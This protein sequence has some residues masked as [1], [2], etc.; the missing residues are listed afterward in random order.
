MDLDD[1][2]RSFTS[3]LDLAN[4]DAVFDKCL[5]IAMEFMVHAAG[6]GLH[7]SLIQVSRYDGD[8]SR[9]HPKWENAPREA[10]IHYLVRIDGKYVDWTRRQFDALAPIPVVVTDLAADGWSRVWE[11]ERE[12][13]PD[14]IRDTLDRVPPI[15]DL[16]L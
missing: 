15:S 2:L 9:C 4:P 3:S 8:M 11:I 12:G 16:S 7:S 5:R 14:W 6:C 10:V 13:A 1:V